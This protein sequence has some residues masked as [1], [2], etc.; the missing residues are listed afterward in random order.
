M[1]Q[2]EIEQQQSN[3]PV[4][5][6]P[7]PVPRVATGAGQGGSCPT[8]SGA[9]QTNISTSANSYVFAIGQI[10]FQYPS[11]SVE[12]E[13][14][15]MAHR[16]KTAGLTDRQVVQNVLSQRDN[17][18]LV[19]M[20]CWV[21]KIEGFATYILMPRVSEDW[22]QLVAALRDS[23]SPMDLDAVIGVQGPVAPPNLC[24]GLTVPVVF[25]D[26]VYSFDRKSLISELRPPEKMPAKE[27]AAAAEELFDRIMRMADNK[28]ATNRDR[29]LNWLAVRCPT[30]YSK[31]AEAFARNF[32]LSAVAVRPSPLSLSGRNIVDVIITYVNRDTNVAEKSIVRVDM[33]D[34]FPFQVSALSPY[35]YDV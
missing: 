11:E 32:W 16:A 33:T 21:L 18:Y 7:N 8:C 29:A 28:G 14:A 2:S 31:T 22:E 9:A 26:K 3:Q 20:L 19:R 5:I 35:Y 24:N 12:K 34:E 6:N 15:Q 23:P 13:I 27:F 1:D 30:I 4:I 10:D 25:F 17:R